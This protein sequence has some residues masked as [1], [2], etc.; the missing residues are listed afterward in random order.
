MSC[1]GTVV[2][3][4]WFPHLFLLQFSKASFQQSKRRENIRSQVWPM[5]N[6]SLHHPCLWVMIRSEAEI[7]RKLSVVPCYKRVYNI[8]TP[9][10]DVDW[11]L[12]LC[13]A[14]IVTQHETF[15]KLC[16]YHIVLHTSRMCSTWFF[17]TSQTP[18]SYLYHQMRQDFRI[19]FSFV[20]VYAMGD[21]LPSGNR[22]LIFCLLETKVCKARRPAVVISTQFVWV[23][24]V[25]SPH[26]PC[27]ACLVRC[28]PTR[29]WSIS[30]QYYAQRELGNWTT[31]GST[32]EKM[33]LVNKTMWS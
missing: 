8:R 32:P 17:S 28:S 21:P 10:F 13:L 7:M 16:I 3:Q 2:H 26:F 4:H 5:L 20:V 9:Y 11:R 22:M 14:P 15:P 29:F 24:L 19:S 1:Y 18:L 30:C 23:V 25:L 12:S 31:V 33:P 6:Q 27:S